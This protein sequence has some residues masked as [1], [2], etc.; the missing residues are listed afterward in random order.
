MQL[1]SGRLP[2]LPSLLIT[3]FAHSKAVRKRA[4]GSGKLAMT[5]SIFFT[6]QG[7]GVKNY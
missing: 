2:R 1:D 5:D 4:M 6:K 3:P 7:C